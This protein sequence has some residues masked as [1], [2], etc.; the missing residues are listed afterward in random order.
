LAGAGNDRIVLGAAATL[1]AKLYVDGGAD[2]DIL[3]DSTGLAATDVVGVELQPVGMPTFVEQGPGG[4]TDPATNL[5]ATKLPASG[6]VSD[7][8]LQP[9][10]PLVQFAATVNGGVWRT[11]DGGTTWTPLT[12][13]LPSLATSAIALAPLDADGAAVI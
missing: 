10:N 4:I 11:T 8:V 2:L 1:A 5:A 13:R 6:A 12:D 7:V 3:E 9:G